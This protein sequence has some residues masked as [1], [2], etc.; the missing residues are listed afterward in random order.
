VNK[1]KKEEYPVLQVDRN[2]LLVAAFT[3]AAVVIVWAAV[4]L[5]RSTRPAGF[6]VMVPGAI[7]AFHSLW[8]M[9]SPFAS[10]YNDRF[11]IRMS[12]F[13]YKQWFFGDIRSVVEKEGG[14]YIVFHDEDIEPLKLFG[15]R[16][17]QLG[18]FIAH[19]KKQ[20]ADAMPA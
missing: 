20:V 12:L 19:I 13:H 11:E 14:H 15:I 9:L 1:G 6:L 7:L 4:S 2:P 5:L 3:M 8:F 16:Q 10:V 17:S 18:G